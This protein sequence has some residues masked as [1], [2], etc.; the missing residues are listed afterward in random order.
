MNTQRVSGPDILTRTTLQFD[1]AI[2][3]P[4]ALE[5]KRALQR[6]PGVLLAEIDG[7]S[8]RATVAHDCAVPIASLLAAVA[9]NGAR[10]AV[11]VDP[12]ARGVSA[13][14]AQP[15]GAIPAQRLFFV[16]AFL[17]LL[18][19]FGTVS[20]S[21]AKN[22]LFIPIVLAFTWAVVFVRAFH[23]RT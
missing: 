21:L 18:P 12:R 4:G 16:A 13:G 19:L 8:D 6:V 14:V 7:A 22:H 5:I 9:A 20:P 15:L 11:V 2:S 17:L 23:H 3:A 10:A 1:T